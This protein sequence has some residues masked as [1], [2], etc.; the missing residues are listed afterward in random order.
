M[1][2]SFYIFLL[3]ALILCSKR[4]LANSNKNSTLAYDNNL[5]IGSV[6]IFLFLFPYWIFGSAS[7]LG[8]YDEYHGQI[9]WFWLKD[10]YGQESFLH[11]YFGGIGI[12]D[13]F[14]SS[15]ADGLGTICVDTHLSN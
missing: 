12:K 15:F 8:G 10:N 1:L 2:F 5:V 11:S 3:I 9:T 7:A 13:S 6:F 4:S 14:N